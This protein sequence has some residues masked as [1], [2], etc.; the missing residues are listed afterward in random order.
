MP[1]SSQAAV[2]K[3]NAVLDGI[4]HILTEIGE[5]SCCCNCR[6]GQTGGNELP[7]E[8]NQQSNDLGFFSKCSGCQVY[9]SSSLVWDFR[10]GVR[11]S[12]DF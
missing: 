5:G 2:E 11:I 9:G 6:S 12:M 7:V 4:E 8:K 3:G 10:F 1:Q